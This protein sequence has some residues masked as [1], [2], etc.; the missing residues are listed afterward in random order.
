MS[1]AGLKGATVFLNLTPAQLYEK[2]RPCTA[3]PDWT[4]CDTCTSCAI[5]S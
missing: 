4:S 3:V 2:A 5:C 1:D